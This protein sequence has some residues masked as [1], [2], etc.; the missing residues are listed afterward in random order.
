MACRILN[1]LKT[2]P[3]D[4]D[5]LNRLLRQQLHWLNRESRSVNDLQGPAYSAPLEQR[6]TGQGRGV[7]EALEEY[8]KL[9]SGA[10]EENG[11]EG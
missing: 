1:L 5:A 7:R 2:K 10:E 8:G 3:R 4:Q 9:E 11:G 6:G